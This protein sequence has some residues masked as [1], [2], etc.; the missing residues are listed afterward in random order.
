MASRVIQKYLARHA[1]PEAQ[2]AEK[3]SGSFGHALI[4]PAYG[5]RESLF[6]LLGSVP[7]G[8]RGPV[9]V[10]LVIN[11]REGS[12]AS[13]HQANAAVR[14]RLEEELPLRNRFSDNPPAR[15]YA[16][17]GG[18][19]V[20]IDRGLPGHYLPESQGVG[21]ARKIGNDLALALAAQDRLS[22]RW[23]LN[24]DADTLLPSDYFDQMTGVPK[25]AAAAV[26]FFDHRF[27]PDVD[28]TEAARLYEISLRYYVLG[29]AWAGSPYAYQSMGSCL[30]ISPEAYAA[31]RGFPKKNAAE[32]F[33]VLNKLAKVGSIIRLA[34]SPVS[35]EGRPSDRVPFG[36]GRAIR[37]LV[38]TKRGLANFRLL[39]PLVFAHLSGW[40]DLLREIARSRDLTKPLGVLPQGNPFFRV[41][42]LQDALRKLCT[43]EAVREAVAKS[44]D[45]A[46]L[47]RHLHTWFDAFKTLK[48]VHALRDGGLVSLPWREALA[49]APFARLS[50]STQEDP[51]ALRRL[52]AEEE[53]KLARE[54]A[55]LGPG[56]T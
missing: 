12:P 39:H 26:Y 28:L 11:A 9:L 51:E 55:G 27:E 14:A 21:L 41:D 22:S 4:I 56:K 3:L 2:L 45:E 35:L 34:G 6:P 24:T 43:F 23:F 50:S 5:E 53:K 37:D 8:P 29:L 42:L 44:S 48:L 30:A 46:T 54:P 52:L 19:L 18:T 17:A 7:T 10:V 36:T 1:E 31:V 16:I 32:D 20:T 49:E 40:L 38:S 13:V 47:A 25:E 15:E 33:Y